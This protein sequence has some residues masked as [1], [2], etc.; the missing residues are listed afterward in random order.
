MWKNK[1]SPPDSD[2]RVLRT[3]FLEDAL[4]DCHGDSRIGRLRKVNQD[5]FFFMPLPLQPTPS[6]PET[7][8]YLLGVA[9]G[10]GGA[11]AGERA[12][13]LAVRTLKA[14]ITE[15]S[16]RLLQTGHKDAE[17]VET[18]SRGLRRCQSALAEEV[19]RHPEYRGMGTTLTAAVVLWPRLYVFHMGDSRAYLLRDGMLRRLTQ[20]QTYA[21]TLMDAGVLDAGTASRSRWK[22]VVWNVLGG[23]KGSGRDPEVHPAV[24][25]ED[26]RG[27]DLLLLCTDGLSN[28]L[29]DETLRDLLLKGG[30]SEDI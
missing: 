7:K 17:I 2:S 9:D 29:P 15:E 25:I 24:H 30:S 6:L 18:F 16:S 14:F 19:S 11:P 28:P 12:S 10:V 8:G 27:G 23:R 21:R 26:L 20:D 3:T 5:R 22:H 13:L 4:L 1:Y